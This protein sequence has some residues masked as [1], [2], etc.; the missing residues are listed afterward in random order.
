MLKNKNGITLVAL[1]I[2]I[3]VLLIL[4]GITINIVLGENGLINK[5]KTATSKYKN[6]QDRENEAIRQY[7]NDLNSYISGNRDYEN[8]INELRQEIARLQDEL[9]NKDEILKEYMDNIV[10]DL[11]RES[12]KKIDVKDVLT[13]SFLTKMATSKVTAKMMLDNNT[14][15][16]NLSSTFLSCLNVSLVPTLSN[17]TNV[18]CNSIYSNDWTAYMGFTSSKCWCNVRNQNS[19]IYLGYDFT[20]N[21]KNVR[22]VKMYNGGTQ[23]YPAKQ[24][25]LQCSNDNT[26]WEDASDVYTLANSS[27]EVFLLNTKKDNSYRSWRLYML[28][29]YKEY[30]EINNIAF[31]GV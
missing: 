16:S 13:N 2:T 25:K 14:F 23:D 17:N 3:V 30:I 11:L 29:A 7:E 18:L 9:N 12:K 4:A 22:I 5:A 26:T 20:N 19:N 8:E 15:R 21:P 31:Y 1:I 10:I 6:E 24:I 28:S 27:K